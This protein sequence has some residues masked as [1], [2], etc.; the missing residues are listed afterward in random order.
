VF[1]AVDVHQDLALE[2]VQ[3][4][5]LVGVD[6]QGCGLALRHEILE[7]QKRAGGFFGAGLHCEHPATPEAEVLSLSV[8]AHDRNGTA[9]FVRSFLQS[10]CKS[11]LIEQTVP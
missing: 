7:Q 11:F 10:G 4:L 5:V 8:S 9:H 6:V 3:G 2:H 1:T